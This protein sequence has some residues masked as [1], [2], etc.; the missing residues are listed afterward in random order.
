ML[1][2]TRNSYSCGSF[3]TGNPVTSQLTKNAVPV[4]TIVSTIVA[5]HCF[6]L[7]MACLLLSSRISGFLTY[8]KFSYRK[9]NLLLI[10]MATKKI[11]TNKEQHSMCEYRIEKEGRY[12]RYVTP[13]FQDFRTNAKGRWLGREVLEV[14]CREFGAHPPSYWKNALRNG[15]VRINNR[16]VAADYKFKNS[17]A[18]LHRAHRYILYAILYTFPCFLNKAPF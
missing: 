17:D 6:V 9:T 2:Q 10:N 18:L 7:C 12:T 4:C 13:Y 16:I 8:S 15:Q 5:V 11:H 1:F 3:F 14:F